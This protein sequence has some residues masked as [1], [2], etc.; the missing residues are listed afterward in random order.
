MELYSLDFFKM[1]NSMTI[2]MLEVE[3]DISNGISDTLVVTCRGRV[4]ICKA[5]E[6]GL[7]HFQLYNALV[8]Q[9]PILQV[10]LPGLML[11]TLHLFQVI[12]EW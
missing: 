7:L 6:I 11:N 12:V 3:A 4:I 9:Y 5:W 10:P 1:C 8:R 2:S